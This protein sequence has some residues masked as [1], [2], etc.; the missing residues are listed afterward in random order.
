MKEAGD[1]C[2]IAFATNPAYVALFPPPLDL[3]SSLQWLFRARLNMLKA[4]GA[5]VICAVDIASG[6]IIG[7]AAAIPPKCY[8]SMWMK[9]KFGLLLWPYRFGLYS[10]QRAL[11]L[12]GTTSEMEKG[13]VPQGASMEL[14]ALFTKKKRENGTSAE[15]EEEQRLFSSSSSRPS[16]PP[17]AR[18]SVDMSLDEGWQLQNVAVDE[19]YRRRGVC[20]SLLNAALEG[21]SASVSLTTQN[22]AAEEMYRR[23]GFVV[24]ARMLVGGKEPMPEPFVSTMMCRPPRGAAG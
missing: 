3:L 21:V 18:S 4:A 20:S 2:A 19:A 8:P 9:F 11:Y 24:V 15:E 6:A 17:L 1:L 14:H 16:S 5:R 7:V 12:D 23:N 22:Y 10:F 13:S